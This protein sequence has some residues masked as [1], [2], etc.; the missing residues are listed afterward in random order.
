[1]PGPRVQINDVSATPRQ[2]DDDVHAE[3]DEVLEVGTRGHCLVFGRCDPGL[4]RPPRVQLLVIIAGLTHGD[5]AYV[6][7]DDP[8]MTNE[9]ETENGEAE[10]RRRRERGSADFDERPCAIDKRSC[11]QKQ[12]G[13][14]IDN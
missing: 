2:K 8:W 14:T 4:A 10:L 5:L 13:R 9:T 11:Q 12:F 1:M 3:T 6:Q 7:V